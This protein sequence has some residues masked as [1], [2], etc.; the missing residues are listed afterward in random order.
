MATIVRKTIFVVDDDPSMR[1][2]VKHLLNRY[3]FET[4]LFAS[5]EDFHERADVRRPDC[6][7]LDVKLKNGSGI[8]SR[9]ELNKSGVSVP[10]I[11]I[12][13]NDTDHRSLMPLTNVTG[14]FV[15][16]SLSGSIDAARTLVHN[17]RQVALVGDPLDRQPFRGHFLGELASAA[18]NLEIINLLGLPLEQVKK[19][20]ASLPNS[21]AVLYTTV[22]TDG[23]GHQYLPNEAL[24]AIAKTANRPIVVDVDN[25][26]GHGATGGVVIVSTLIGEEAAQLMLRVFNGENASMIPITISKAVKPIFDWRELQRWAVNEHDLP[27]GSEILFRSPTA[28]EQYRAYILA[29]IAAI[30]IQS[31]LISWLLYEHR[32]RREA[33]VEARQRMS[34]LAHMNRWATV[35]E[36]S[37]SLAHELNQPLGAILTNAETAELIANSPSPD[38]AEIKEIMADIKRDDHRAGEIIRMRSCVKFLTLSRSRPLRAASH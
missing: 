37:A 24:A 36:L 20:V 27:P 29:A 6:L 5:V 19:R 33:E 9:K 15:Q 34:E 22:T 21:S 13:A 12:T 2:G 17:L 32:R 18:A 31:A 38:M 35:G 7:V 23:T 11:F 14:R 8:D 10:A 1:L 28:W 3:G 16:L 4:E 30:L 26:L 25:R